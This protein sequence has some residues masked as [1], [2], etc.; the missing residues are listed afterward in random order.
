MLSE[1]KQVVLQEK[2]KQ[3]GGENNVPENV[4]RLVVAIGMHDPQSEEDV[5]Q[6]CA[7][8]LWSQEAANWFSKF[9]GYLEEQ[10]ATDKGGFV[11]TNDPKE[12]I[13]AAINA[14]Q[15]ALELMNEQRDIVRG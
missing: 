5:D 2:V 9:V 6:I 10:K 14:L 3:W 4:Q 8:N 15:Q 13:Q 7:E 1:D 12:M 11:A